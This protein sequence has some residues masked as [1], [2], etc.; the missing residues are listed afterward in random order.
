M[1]PYMTR[2]LA[3]GTAQDPQDGSFKHRQ[4]SAQDVSAQLPAKRVATAQARAALVGITVDQVQGDFGL[5]LVA[6]RW[7]LCK[8]FS[9]LEQLEAWLDEVD[10]AR[11]AEVVA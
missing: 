8:R 9:S 6:T 11:T 7:A 5:E 3:A 2:A 10:A 1:A 4:H